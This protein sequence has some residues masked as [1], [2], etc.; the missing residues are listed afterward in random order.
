M[1]IYKMTIMHI[2]VVLQLLKTVEQKEENEI[3]N[4]IAYLHDVKKSIEK[5][6][7]SLEKEVN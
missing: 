4:N 5:L 3:E 6:I 1:N 2:E 7:S